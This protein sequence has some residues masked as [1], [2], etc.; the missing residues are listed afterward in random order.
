LVPARKSNRFSRPTWA[1]R[2]WPSCGHPASAPAPPA[3]T[4]LSLVSA[5][6]FAIT[7]S[8]LQVDDN[9][10][11]ARYEVS[12]NGCPIGDTEFG[13]FTDSGLQPGTLYNYAVVAIDSL[14]NRSPAS[15]TLALR[16]AGEPVIGDPDADHGSSPGA[17]RPPRNMPPRPTTTACAR[18]CVP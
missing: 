18:P 8:W 12:R 14:G 17:C 10:A 15:I 7:L 4:D 13:V 6:E 9:W 3:P 11:I 2:S 16:T 5:T 1:L